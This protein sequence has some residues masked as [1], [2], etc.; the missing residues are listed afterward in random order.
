MLAL[1][2]LG[3]LDEARFSEIL[4]EAKHFPGNQDA[5]VALLEILAELAP[6]GAPQ[7]EVFRTMLGIRGAIYRNK[8]LTRWAEND[9]EAAIR[10]FHEK[11]ASGELVSTAVSDGLYKETLSMLLD[12]MVRTNPARAVAFFSELKTPPDG[13]WDHALQSLARGL[14]GQLAAGKSSAEF[15]KLLATTDKALLPAIVQGAASTAVQ[16]KDLEGYARFIEKYLSGPQRDEAILSHIASGSI[17]SS[18][19]LDKQLADARQFLPGMSE[20]DVIS[21]LVA[22]SAS[23]NLNRTSDWA[24]DLPVGESRDAGLQAFAQAG[25]SRGFYQRALSSAQNIGDP[26]MRNATVA[27]VAESWLQNDEATA[28]AKL[29]ADVLRSLPPQTAPQ[30]R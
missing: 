24:V 11:N 12:G 28:R 7:E 30:S 22:R 4:V 16:E 27:S 13:G 23:E 6:P 15:E 5:R 18:V 14:G 1:A 17:S 21:R 9:P 2:S 8:T 20:A 26:A 3:D 19:P 25:A 29:P 10:W